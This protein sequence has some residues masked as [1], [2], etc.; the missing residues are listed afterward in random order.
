MVM[1]APGLQRLHKKKLSSAMPRF[2]DP[3]PEDRLASLI[4][5]AIVA[6][7]HERFARGIIYSDSTGIS[8]DRDGVL[9]L[10]LSPRPFR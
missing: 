1:A 10:I 8:N 6:V 5:A 7:A 2:A 4:A 3:V 9:A